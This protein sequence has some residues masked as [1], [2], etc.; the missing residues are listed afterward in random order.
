MPSR[1]ARP[2]RLTPPAPGPRTRPRPDRTDLRGPHSLRWRGCSRPDRRIRRVSGR[3]GYF[4]RRD[5]GGVPSSELWS[6]EIAGG[7][8]G[9][10]AVNKERAGMPSS[11]AR[12]WAR[13]SAWRSWT[14]VSSSNVTRSVGC[15]SVL[16]GECRDHVPDALEDAL[17]Q[18]VLDDRRQD[19]FPAFG[20]GRIGHLAEPHPGLRRPLASPPPLR[21]ACPGTAS[22]HQQGG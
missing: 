18:P 9:R 1:L 13:R 4:T 17:V 2:S 14:S 16:A 3:H 10:Q 15:V 6:Y 5:R 7:S 22:R 12:S 20:V 19:R 8:A 11:I 21:L